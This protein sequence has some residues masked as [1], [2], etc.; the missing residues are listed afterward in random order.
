MVF[1]LKAEANKDFL[2]RII[3]DVTSLRCLFRVVE[4]KEATRKAQ[5][6]I[7]VHWMI[8][9]L[10]NTFFNAWTDDETQCRVPLCWTICVLAVR[11]V[12]THTHTGSNHRMELWTLFQLLSLRLND[13]P[14]KAFPRQRKVPINC[15][16]L[17]YP[18]YS[19]SLFKYKRNGNKSWAEDSWVKYLKK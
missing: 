12:C 14:K 9:L 11:L 16:S 1:T 10:L 18:L 4:S 19:D 13:M 3:C 8:H 15:F 5:K 7:I 2:F 17:P 6:E